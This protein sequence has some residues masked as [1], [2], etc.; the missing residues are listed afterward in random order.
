MD[1]NVLPTEFDGQSQPLVVVW[2]VSESCAMACKFCGYSRELRRE[3]LAANPVDVL[4]FGSVLSEVQRAGGRSVLVSWLGGEPLAWNPLPEVSHSF[5]RDFALRL[6]VTSNGLPLASK[7]LRAMLIDDYE[8]V[9]ISIDGLGPFHDWVR[10]QSGHF[11]RIR[12]LVAQLRCEDAAGRLVLRVNTV[13]MRDNIAAFPAFCAAMADWGFHE[14]TFN[15]LGGNERPEF[16][17][18]HRL[19]PQQ[20]QRFSEDLPALRERMLCRGLSIRGSDRYLA[21]IAATTQGVAIPVEDCQPATEFL[22]ID[23]SGY[24]SPCSFSSAEYRVHV[25][26][27]TSVAQ[28]DDLPRRF[29]ALRLRRRLAAC[30]D[31]HATHLFDKFKV[32]QVGQVSAE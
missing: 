23:A 22:F 2:R 26:E 21:R 5:A 25:S 7:A 14:L 29:R 19:L 31:C 32:T 24:I 17:A 18:K 20:I 10:S 9:T 11:A 15:Q 27:I 1:A 12:E 4:G 3:R 16:F 28:F 13:L 30:N 6:G 8:Q